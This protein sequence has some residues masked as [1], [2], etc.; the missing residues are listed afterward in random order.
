MV[1]AHMA[2]LGEGRR[3]RQ[4][5][6]LPVYVIASGFGVHPNTVHN[7]LRSGVLEG[8]RLSD[9]LKFVWGE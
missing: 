7:W 1:Q 9:I 8:R 4:D 2:K 6:E 3:V 5:V